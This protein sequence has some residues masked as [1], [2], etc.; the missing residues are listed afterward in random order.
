MSRHV[1]PNA[2][3]IDP[4][5]AYDA[6]APHYHAVAARREHYLQAVEQIIVK[7]I[8]EANSL[9]DLGAGDGARTLRIAQAARIG[10][11]AAVE[12]SARMC[13]ALE[14][15]MPFWRCRLTEL[16]DLEMKF[17]V[18]TCL[19]N[20]LGHLGTTEERVLALAKARK[21][22]SPHGSLF[23]DVNHRHNASAYGWAKTL[24][25]IAHD[26]MFWRCQDGDVT[27]SWNVGGRPIRTRGH[28]FIEKEVQGLCRRAGL[29]INQCWAVN[30]ETGSVQDSSLLGNLLYRL[31]VPAG[32]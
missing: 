19:W 22:L 26:G 1:H 15:K 30:Y 8:G 10:C 18:I 9:L 24:W 20:V 14:G 29:V 11:V 21:L 27:V 6:L 23:I 4:V 25:R 3:V 5:A 13:E 28:L 7:Q 17:D 31:S 16:P 12:P 2:D 32:A